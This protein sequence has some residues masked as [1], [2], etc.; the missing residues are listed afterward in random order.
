MQVIIDAR[1]ATSHFPGIGRYVS[2]LLKAMAV[3]QNDMSLHII[4]SPA[5]IG[6]PVASSLQETVSNASVFSLR[7]QWAIPKLINKI[8]GSLYHSTYYLM[9]YRVN[10]PVVFTCYDLIPIV[11]PQYFSPLQRMIYRVAHH[12]A[13]RASSCIIAISESTKS[14]LTKYFS[15]DER[16]ISAIPLAADKTFNPQSMNTIEVVRS[17]FD[18]PRRYCL[19]VGTNKPHKNLLGLL[20]AWKL[21]HDKKALEDHSLVIAGKWDPRYPEAKEFTLTSGLNKVVTFTGEVNEE[22]LPALYSGATIFVQPSLYE[23]F[24]LPIIEAMACGTAV[25]CSNTSS[26][27]EVAGDAAIL[28]DPKD[29][30]SIADTLG[31]LLADSN[32]LSSLREKSIQQASRFSWQKTALNT[33]DIYRKVCLSSNV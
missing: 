21:L 17:N 26:L 24:G 3:L 5:P 20:N 13:A 19:Y 29:T 1:T 7:Q 31:S 11:Y 32:K 10:V 12:I 28:F 25:T 18:L 16:K 15:I 27:P 2:N 6:C 4:R 33:I 14:D 22:H 8:G 9:P 23:G 30:K